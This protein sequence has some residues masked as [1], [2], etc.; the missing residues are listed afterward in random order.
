[1]I[2]QFLELENVTV[3]NARAENHGRFD[4]REMYEVVLARA[5]G[6]LNVLVEL[7]VPL[8]CEGGVL[9]A[10]KGDRAEAEIAHAATALKLL[11]AQSSRHASYG[12]RHGCQCRQG[13]ANQSPLSTS[14]G[15]TQ[16]IAIGRQDGK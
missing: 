14:P 9:V 4:G 16:A 10:V 5:V 2:S 11:G 8:L 7:A 6:P 1:M 12:N 13:I 15:G 3:I